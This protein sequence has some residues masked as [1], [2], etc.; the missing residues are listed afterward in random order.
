MLKTWV[1]A[2]VSAGFL[3]GAAHYIFQPNKPA[4]TNAYV[5]TN[6]LSVVDKPD[7]VLTFS[8]LSCGDK[9]TIVANTAN[10]LWVETSYGGRDA[11]VLGVNNLSPTPPK[12]SVIKKAALAKKTHS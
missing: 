2:L 1:Y 12:C 8:K 3:V 5:V 6:K 9:I 11:Y 4:T 10:N 7:G